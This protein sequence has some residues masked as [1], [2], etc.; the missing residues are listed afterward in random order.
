MLCAGR[1][2]PSFVLESRDFLTL[3]NLT[4]EELSE[5]LDRGRAVKADPDLF[6]TSLQGKQIA[7]IFEKPSTRTR[8]SFEA[9]VTSQ[10]GHAIVLR[11]DELQL[12]RGETIE[13]TGRVLSRYVDCIV[14]RTF[15]QDRLERL[16]E[17]ASVPV[18]NALS[19]QEHP[20]QCLA[21]LQTI[22][23]KHGGLSERVLAYIGD[24]NNV[25]HALMLGGVMMGMEVRVAT[26]PDYGP[27]P[28]VVD[29]CNE[30]GRAT[31]GSVTVT[32]D[33]RSA[34]KGAHVL[35]TDVWTS[36]GQEAENEVRLKALADF[37]VNQDL[38]DLASRDAIVMHC[39]P[40]HRGEEI[41]AA[42]M[43]GPRSVVWDQA[44]NR[45]HS[46]KAL[47]TYLIR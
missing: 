46:Q 35:Y 15:G 41:S 6:A 9:A 24:G 22:Q 16:A 37:Q 10:G 8:V 44:E 17:A 1:P 18:V 12:G 34:S 23:E 4:P 42:V 20:C 36:M 2:G 43:D 30:I 32:N 33:P 13:D 25:A 45:L 29:R 47:L 21:D 28:R 38:V 19:D 27:F 26:P 3:D 14:I 40:A 39:L 11:G 5:I 31:G 7:L